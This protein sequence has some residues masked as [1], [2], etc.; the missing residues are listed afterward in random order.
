MISETLMAGGKKTK[1]RTKLLKHRLSPSYISRRIPL[2]ITAKY[3][4]KRHSHRIP[5]FDVEYGC[6]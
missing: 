2:R 5:L 6:S 1:K 4:K 3:N